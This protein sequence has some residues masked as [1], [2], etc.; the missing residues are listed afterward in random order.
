M[1][2]FELSTLPSVIPKERIENNRCAKK[3][4]DQIAQE[5]M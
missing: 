1:L 4:I 3:R 2:H 5:K